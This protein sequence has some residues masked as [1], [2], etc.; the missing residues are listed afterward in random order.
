MTNEQQ[1]KI[2]ELRKLC[3]GYRGIVMAMNVSRDKVINY[4]KAQ[5]LDELKT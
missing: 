3:I 5:G 1:E 4:C 2:I